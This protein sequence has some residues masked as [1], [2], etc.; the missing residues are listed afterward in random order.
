MFLA[1]EET[2]RDERVIFLMSTLDIFGATWVRGLMIIMSPDDVRDCRK[3]IVTGC[4]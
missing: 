1:T 3:K 4:V 2:G